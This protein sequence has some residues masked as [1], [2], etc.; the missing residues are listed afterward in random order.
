[1][2]QEQNQRLDAAGVDVR[3]MQAGVRGDAGGGGPVRNTRVFLSGKP[4]I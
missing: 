3:R 2:S 1:M 4:E